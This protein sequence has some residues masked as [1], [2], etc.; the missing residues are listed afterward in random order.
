MGPPTSPRPRRQERDAGGRRSRDYT[1]QQGG[2]RGGGVRAE[3]VGALA[4]AGRDLAEVTIGRTEKAY[5]CFIGSKR[6]TR[7]EPRAC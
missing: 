3:H 7:G 6:T 5:A 1:A 2:D 4:S